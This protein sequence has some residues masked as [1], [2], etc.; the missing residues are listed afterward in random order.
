MGGGNAGPRGGIITLLKERDVR[1]KKEGEVR[2][3]KKKK[4]M[5]VEE[6]QNVCYM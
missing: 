2:E 1:R 3:K 6:R 4:P 5:G